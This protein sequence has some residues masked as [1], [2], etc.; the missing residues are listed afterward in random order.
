MATETS[1]SA[2]MAARRP[3]ERGAAPRVLGIRAAAIVTLLA[4]CLPAGCASVRVS[5]DYD[6]GADFA[7]LETWSWSPKAPMPTGDIRVDDNSLL[8]MRVRGAVEAELA[9]RGYRKLESGQPDF[10]VAYHA[11]INERLDVQTV[12]D[13]YGYGPGWG[14]GYPAGGWSSRTYVNQYEEGTLI[15]DVSIPETRHLIWRGT[16]ATEMD[17]S[18]TPAERQ[19]TIRAA[20]A[21]MLSYFP[22]AIEPA[23]ETEN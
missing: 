12:N 9:A 14:W 16:A 10:H 20:V 8:D 7:A 2:T 17:D 3:L 15:L 1:T 13:Y 6:P 21:K 5:H 22:P 11:A 18:A 19:Q 4:L 23:A